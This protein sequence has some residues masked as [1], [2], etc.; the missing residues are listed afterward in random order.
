MIVIH[1]TNPTAPTCTRYEDPCKR[2]F[3]IQPVNEVISSA[4]MVEF[5]LEP[6]VPAAFYEALRDFQSQ[7]VVDL[8]TALGDTPPNE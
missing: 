1:E 6:P 8:D 3:V 4:H 2:S 7:R 5:E